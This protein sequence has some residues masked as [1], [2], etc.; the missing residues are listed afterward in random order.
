MQHT[1]VGFAHTSGGLIKIKDHEGHSPFDVYGTTIGNRNIHTFNHAQTIGAGYSD[2][3]ENDMAQGVSGDPEDSQVP[4][5]QPQTQVN[6]DEMF[7]F[8]SNKN[9]TLGLGDEDDRQFPERVYLNRPDRLM[10]SFYE[11]FKSSSMNRPRSTSDEKRS[12]PFG[13]FELPAAVRYRPLTVQDVQLSKLSSTILTNDPQANLYMCGFGSGGRL[14]TGDESTRFSYVNIQ[15]GGLGAKRVIHIALGQNHTIAIT[16]EGETYTWGNNA[17]GQL[18]YAPN[19]NAAG[20]KDEDPVQLLPRQVFGPLKREVV[21]G[22]AASRIHSAVITSTSLYTF[23][24]NEGQMGLVDSDARSLI[25]QNTPRKVGASLFTSSIKSVSA[26]DKATICLLESHEVL[27]FANYGYTKIVFPVE[28]TKFLQDLGRG[29]DRFTETRPVLRGNQV[30]KITSGGDTICAMTALGDVFTMQ[31]ALSPP[32]QVWALRKS[33]MAVRDVDVGQDG[34]IIICTEAGS[35]WRRVKRATIKDATISK[36][37]DYKAKDYKFSRVPGLTR[38]AA[39]R[40]N[41]FGAYAAMRRD[42][43]VLQTQ[44]DVDAVSLWKDL[45]PLLPFHGF[46]AEDSDTEDPRPRFWV[47]SQPDDVATIRQAVLRTRTLET[48]IAEFL[49]DRTTRDHD[50]DLQVGS[51]ICDARIPVH[52]FMF[53]GRSHILNKALTVFQKEYFYSVQDVF[54]IEYDS[55]GKPII[56]FQGIDFITLINLVLYVYT[57]S[58]VSVWQFRRPPDMALRYRQVRVELMKVASALEMRRLEHAVRLMTEPPKTLREDFDHAITF[59]AFFENGDIKVELDGATQMVHGALVCRRC[60]F[61]EGL[62]QGRAAGRW[63]SSRRDDDQDAP[64]PIQVDLTHVSPDVFKYVLRHIYADT[65]ETMFEDVITADLDAYLDLIIEV[66]SVANELMLDRL[67][68]SC[69][70]L[71][72]KH[73][74]EADIMLELDETVQQ[75]QL[76]CMPFAKSGKAEA[77]IVEQYPRLLER[78]ERSKQV[79][80]DRVR[81]QAKLRD[82]NKGTGTLKGRKDLPEDFEQNAPS[83]KSPKIMPKEVSKSP[84]F[85]PQPS[86]H[87]LMFDMDGLDD[88]QEKRSSS[89]GPRSDSYLHRPSQLNNTEFDALPTSLESDLAASTSPYSHNDLIRSPGIDLDHFQ[90]HSIALD[91]SRPWAAPGFSASKLNMKE[92]MAQASSLGT[93]SISTALATREKQPQSPQTPRK[94]SVP[95][96]VSQ[97]ERK[98]QQQEQLAQASSPPVQVA[99]PAPKA[100]PDSQAKPI[101]PWQRASSGSRISLKDILGEETKSPSPKD[102]VPHPSSPSMTLRQTVAGKPP[103]RHPFSD[104]S[105]TPAAPAQRSVS[106]P[107]STAPVQAHQSPLSPPRSLSTYTPP[108]PTQPQIHSIRHS[109]PASAA[110]PSLQLSMSDILSQQQTEKDVIRDAVAKRSL[111]EIQEEQAFQEWWDAESRKVQLEEQGSKNGAGKAGGRGRVRRARG[112]GGAG[113]AKG[114]AW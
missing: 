26:I 13:I 67:T 110:E 81:L 2:D 9:L 114:G 106:S 41:T 109:T 79:K 78:F 12:R 113:A 10:Y 52:T 25:S 59:P 68:Q 37:S 32:Q 30:C 93:S 62:F 60:P 40:S 47:S 105:Q 80:I 48:D 20:A 71:L 17:F 5:L 50:F 46:G 15:G 49:V 100:K 84:K 38:I 65:D 18:G 75:N 111:Q 6:G 16:N 94:S 85:A 8:G 77:D 108:V 55:E 42:C 27:V 82:E 21:I 101:S 14:G 91:N 66:M 86:T 11:G 28:N 4:R 24:K 54:N 39:V 87:D 31:G 112:R 58:V 99:T 74:L 69:Q 44:I 36:A 92:I 64:E 56:L 1:S 43:D 29:N 102:K 3:E 61:F 76:N 22:A 103:S 73:E 96:K 97:K 57:D 35:V 104:S 88:Q 89:A 34:S 51:T 107:T 70:K 83:R 33:H 98:R 7:A 19:A 90:D 95:Q 72:G 23:G 45:Y 63:L 53:A